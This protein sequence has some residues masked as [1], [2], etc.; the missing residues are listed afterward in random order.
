[1]AVAALGQAD[2]H[3]LTRVILS[4]WRGAAVFDGLA[5]AYGPRCLPLITRTGAKAWLR[6]QGHLTARESAVRSL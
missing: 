1:M 5:Q 4:Q 6:P 3:A 2:R